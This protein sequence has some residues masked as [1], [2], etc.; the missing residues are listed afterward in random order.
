MKKHPNKEIA[1]AIDY[2]ESK[3][4]RIKECRGHAWG[5]M[6]CPNN[7]ETCRCGEFC[8]SSIWSTPKNAGNHAKHI[9]QVVDNCLHQQKKEQEQEQEVEENKETK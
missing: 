2:A 1:D 9:R 7:D 6:L 8:K 5:Q 3:H 4:W